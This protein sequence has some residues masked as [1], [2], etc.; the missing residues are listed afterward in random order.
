MEE[1]P[2]VYGKNIN[3]G[4]ITQLKSIDNVLLINSGALDNLTDV[5][6]TTPSLGDTLT[7]DGTNWVNKTKDYLSI[8]MHGSSDTTLYNYDTGFKRI[9]IPSTAFWANTFYVTKY[10][11]SSGIVFNTS[12]GIISGLN[13]S[14]TYFVDITLNLNTYNLPTT[15]IWECRLTNGGSPTVTYATSKTAQVNDYGGTSMSIKTNV[16]G[17]TTLTFE[18]RASGS[19]GGG[20]DISGTSD[21]TNLALYVKE[22]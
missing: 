9:I 21:D 17:T 6:I 11:S 1:V 2:I 12:T 3:T 14:K 15:T 5:A 18:N 20:L 10:V 8:T 4:T 19:S 16:T 13:S 7:Y 22:I